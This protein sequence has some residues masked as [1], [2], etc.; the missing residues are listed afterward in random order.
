[1]LQT[2]FYRNIMYIFTMAREIQSIFIYN[3]IYVTKK[4]ELILHAFK[5]YLYFGIKFTLIILYFIIVP[6]YK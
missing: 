5:L 6:R 3:Y 1:M 2:L 4:K